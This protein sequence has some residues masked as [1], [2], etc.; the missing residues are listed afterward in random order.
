MRQRCLS[1]CIAPPPPTACSLPF[2]HAAPRH[3]SSARG[4][5]SLRCTANCLAFSDDDAAHERCQREG[6][7]VESN[8]CVPIYRTSVFSVV[9]FTHN[10]IIGGEQIFMGGTLLPHTVY[11]VD[12]NHVKACRQK[13]FIVE[14]LSVDAVYLVRPHHAG[15]HGSESAIGIQFEERGGIRK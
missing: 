2:K 12:F 7:L 5:C 8:V 4:A 11:L 15:F 10:V 1:R 13:A 6:G 14:W 9:P 3:T